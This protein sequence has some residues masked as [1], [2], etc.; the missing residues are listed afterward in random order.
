MTTNTK[1][2]AVTNT[3]AHYERSTLGTVG[4]ASPSTIL[5]TSVAASRAAKSSE[6]K[7]AAPDMELLAD[8]N[9]AL[10]I[11]FDQYRVG[12]NKSTVLKLREMGPISA[13]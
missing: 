13:P 5:V 4:E 3:P 8:T 10:G 6:L 2:H 7:C 9:G 12:T 11:C 1:M